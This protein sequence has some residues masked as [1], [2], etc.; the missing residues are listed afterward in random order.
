MNK[1]DDLTTLTNDELL[2]R[3]VSDALEN[4]A[5]QEGLSG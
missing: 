4:E 1:Y 2:D 3:Y 5:A